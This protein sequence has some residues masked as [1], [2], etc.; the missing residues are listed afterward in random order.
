MKKS[1]KK[2]RGSISAVKLY[3]KVCVVKLTSIQMCRLKDASQ[4]SMALNPLHVIKMKM[5]FNG[6]CPS[7]T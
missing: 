3:S 1:Q 4:L 5:A 6:I 2:P 7:R